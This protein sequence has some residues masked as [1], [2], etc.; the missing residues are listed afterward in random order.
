MRVDDLR[1]LPLFGDLD[2]GQIAQL[3]A[4]GTAVRIEPGVELFREGEPADSWWALV[5]GEI[6]LSRRVGREDTVVGRMDG[7]GRWAGGFR[8][9]DERGVYLATGRGTVDGRVLRVPAAALGELAEAWFPF[10][11]H[12]ISGLYHTARSIE[13]TARQRQSLVALGTLAAGI[14]HQINNPAAAAGRAVD[15][16]DETLRT[17]VSTLGL[18]AGQDVSAAQFVAVDA[19]RAELASRPVVTDALA[20]SDLEGDLEAWLD[21]HGVDRGWLL[22]P[23]LAAAGA[24]T[25]WCARA[26]GA[27]DGPALGPALGWVA[28]TVSATALLA[29]LKESTGRISELVGT[30]KSYSQMDR[31]SMQRV[32]V[33]EGIDSTLAML[34]HRTGGVTI[35]REYA[36]GVPPIDAHAGELNQVWTH[37]VDNALD[38]MDGS[39]TLRVA[40]ELDGTDVAVTVSDTGPGMVPEVAERAFDAF[41]ST[42]DVGRGTGLGLDI[43]RRIVVERHRGTIAID[44]R[45]GATELLVRLPTD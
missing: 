21:D 12:L 44:S 10:G 13:S 31:A 34:G 7:P 18:L 8:A 43:A 45:P 15:E 19:L 40:V 37:L 4:A 41:F 39:G 38:A 16:L 42:K 32:D 2:D 24:D 14:A 9:W 27:V 30:V 23:A 11:S 17:L 29:E 26:A 33:A 25:G 1:S 28:S 36:P 20:L 6:E 35:V 3:V 5:D 22:A